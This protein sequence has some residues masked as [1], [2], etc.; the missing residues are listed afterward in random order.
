MAE[1]DI[2]VDLI[3]PCEVFSCLGFLAAAASLL[4]AAE[5]VFDWRDE[6]NTKFILGASGARTPFEAVLEFLAKSAI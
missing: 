2:P 1:A 4:G 5:G 3:H 6:A